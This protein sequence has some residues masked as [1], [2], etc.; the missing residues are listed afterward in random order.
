MIQSN[1]RSSVVLV[2]VVAALSGCHWLSHLGGNDSLDLSKADLQAMQVD[3][4][5]DTKT[6]CPREQVQMAIAVDAVLEGEKEKKRFETWV[7]KEDVNKNGKVEFTDFAF[8]S[9]QGVFDEKGWFSPSGSILSTVDKEYEIKT[10]YRRLPEKLSTTT[11]YRP[12]YQCIRSGGKNGQ[13]GSSGA[14]GSLGPPGSPG[15]NGTI[16]IPGGSGTAGGAGIAGGD[17]GKGGDGPH[18]VARATLVKTAF[19]ERLIAI[20]LEG[21]VEDF[22]LAPLDHPIV[23]NARGGSG[24]IGGYGGPGGPGGDGG[25][26]VPGGSGGPGGPGGSAGRGGGGGHGGT[27]ALVLDARYP[28]LVHLITLNVTGG[29]GGEA[30]AAGAGGPGG[31]PGSGMVPNGSVRPPEN[32]SRGRD[33]AR[34]APNRSGERGADGQ[35]TATAGDVAGAFAGIAGIARLEDAVIAPASENTI[36]PR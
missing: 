6:I 3:I 16:A 36:R 25:S 20:K 23:V 4:R 29:A 8:Q 30:G 15:Q 27:I 24:G 5:K 12:D 33:G 34:G 35:A 28:E 10:A 17:G 1:V 31:S 19:Y 18:I 14:A 11:K 26:G 7:G 9:T 2:G 13:P 32:G 21:D 22:L